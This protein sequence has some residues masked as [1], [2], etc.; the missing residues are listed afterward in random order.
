MP[1]FQHTTAAINHAWKTQ[2]H[3]RTAGFGTKNLLNERRPAMPKLLFSKIRIY[4]FKELIR[5]KKQVKTLDVLLSRRKQKNDIRCVLVQK[6]TLTSDA[7]SHLQEDD[8][9][10]PKLEK[11]LEDKRYLAA[12]R[13]F[14]QSEFSEENIEFWLAC[15]EYKESTSSS[16]RSKK[17]A[18]IYHVFLDP[19]A[20]KEVNIDYHTREKIKRSIVNPDPCCFDEA[21]RL[22][23][24]L[25]ERD[26]CPRF[27]KSVAYQNVKRKAMGVG[28]FHQKITS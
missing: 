5:N 22:V 16:M 20:Q 18:E 6:I 10:K 1:K 17:A 12:F 8:I 26:S 23:F 21:E 11:L 2:E 27:L 13:A 4:E 9:L 19:M 7:D 24:K 14:L 15:K 25:M 3:F 28:T